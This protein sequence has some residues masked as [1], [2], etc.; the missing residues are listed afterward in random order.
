MEK[1]HEHIL[2]EF[3]QELKSTLNLSYLTPGLVKR[4]LLTDG[5]VANLRHPNKSTLEKNDEFLNIL[6][7]KGSKAFT[8]FLEALQEEDQHLGHEDLYEKLL[9]A[10][11][12]MN[13]TMSSNSSQS[14]VEIIPDT[15]QDPAN[16]P[17]HSRPRSRPTSASSIGTQLSVASETRLMAAMESL[18]NHVDQSI[19]SLESRISNQIDILKREVQY[20]K[21]RPGS[22]RG[23]SSTLESSSG[24]SASAYE[25]DSSSGG[26]DTNLLQ[27][28]HHQVT[29]PH[30][31]MGLHTNHRRRL[32]KAN[33]LSSISGSSLEIEKINV[34]MHVQGY[35]YIWLYV[36]TCYN[37]S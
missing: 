17:T 4:K 23:S 16:S 11:K 34:C 28:R 5:E 33:Q 12:K 1:R 21:S 36:Y 31:Q 10:D 14:S 6:K 37:Y 35:S 19:K 22:S 2:N 20:L 15:L 25:G 26:S 9:S 13:N 27:H 24:Y 30:W 29:I 3:G 32:F 7:T 8:K 18:K